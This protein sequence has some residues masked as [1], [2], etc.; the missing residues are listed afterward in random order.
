MGGQT[1]TSGGWCTGSG[2]KLRR[3]TTPVMQGRIETAGEAE[4]RHG[5]STR[6]P[7]EERALLERPCAD[8]IRNRREGRELKECEKWKHGRI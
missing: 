3:H 7:N 5:T 8:Q 2:G 1:E 6:E 4:V